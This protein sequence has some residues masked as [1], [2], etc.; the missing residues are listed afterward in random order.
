[1]FVSLTIKSTPMSRLFSLIIFLL[2]VVAGLIS[3]SCAN[4]GTITGGDKDSLPPVMIASRPLMADTNFREDRVLIA[5]NEY[6]EL[7]DINQEFV[8]SP[9]F[10][11]K[12][13]FKV[14]KKTL[15]VKFEEPLKDSV[16]YNLNFG[17]GI[18]DFNE[19][20]VYKDF[21]FIFS[22]YY[23]I[24][25]FS[26]AG[27]LKN[28]FDLS[29]P[30]NTF[31]MIYTNDS[32]SIPFKQIPDYLARID[33][34]GSFIID[35][36]KPGSYK[37]F[38]ISDLN[39]NI[40]ADEFEARAFLDSLIVPVRI[41]QIKIDSLKAGTII[42]DLHDKGMS[43][44][45][46]TDTVI[47]SHSYRNKPTELK[48]YLF[49]EDNLNQKILDFERKT[50]SR[51]DLVFQL[52]VVDDFY[53]KPLNVDIAPENLI[54]E[55]NSLK[56]SLKFW[57]SDSIAILKDS[58][59]VRISYNHKDSLGA[60]EL[61]SDTITFEFREK[62][63]DDA[64]K[65]KKDTE[66]AINK[67]YIKME[68]LA[69]DKMVD[70]DKNLLIESPSPLVSIDTSKIKLFE[71]LDTIVIDTKEQ[72]VEKAFRL[73][74]DLLSFKFKRP[75]ANKFTMQSLNFKNENWY[76]ISSSDSN[77]LYTIRISDPSVAMMDTLKIRLDFDNHFFLGQIQQLS[78]TAIMPLT[79][80]KILNRKREQAD[81]IALVFDKP[82]QTAIEVVPEDFTAQGKWYRIEKNRNS[83]SLIIVLTDKKISDKDTLTFSVKGFDYLNLNEDSVSF[84][85]TMRLIFKEKK[86]F[87]VSVNRAKPNELSLVFNKAIV[88]QPEISP[89]NFT[90]NTK[91]YKLEQNAA[92]DSL[93]Y[94]ITDSFVSEMD[95]FNFIV[96]YKDTDR[97]GVSTVFSDTVLLQNKRKKEINPKTGIEKN[98][99]EGAVNQT[100]HIY[101]PIAYTLSEDSINIRHRLLFSE[102]KSKTKYLLKSDS[103]AFV[104]F[105]GLYNQADNYEFSTRDIEYYSK[106]NLS[107]T[108]I[109]PLD[110][111]YQRIE[112]EADTLQIDNKSEDVYT[113]HKDE[114]QKFIGDGNLIVQLTD[115]K[116]I[117]VKEYFINQDKELPI[118]YL[119]PGK[120]L[121][122]VIYDLNNNRKWDTGNYFK[123]VQPERV[124]IIG[125]IIQ[126]KSGFENN[127]EWNVGES[128]LNSFIAK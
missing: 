120:Y 99:R 93:K 44:S 88:T 126:L 86:Q 59:L 112:A 101:L 46:I 35:H 37:I 102:W 106:L 33:S 128:L 74:K 64:W 98:A 72:M 124:L 100:V 97:K 41:A 26:I 117:L 91:W 118:E 24:D 57:I 53:F 119:H 85:E 62:Q 20:N 19:G 1:M 109:N 5:F 13:E 116:G 87:L 68:Y 65:R 49:K 31:V 36:I 105:R 30:E 92:G 10:L 66:D 28:A 3:Y 94:I 56:D 104:D 78:D 25:S 82:V 111:M 89:L 52:P 114:V 79:A 39:S 83:D 43:D 12:P 4:I 32:D 50:R 23:K 80:Q 70:L 121:V 51:L 21:K 54:I 90:L 95:S 29:V 27:N 115:D 84:S 123:H 17:N 77:R 8:A 45:L 103:M 96:N 108:H 18:A 34:A 11:K 6:F 110:S 63:Q 48:L 16:T 73:K 67:E 69:N 122:K 127:I 40:L 61:I 38:A 14:K 22:T 75:V 9:P 7:K 47:I 113:V 2:A 76:T 125:E 107:I 81:R 15:I 58:L 42:H 55:K 60:I 71:I